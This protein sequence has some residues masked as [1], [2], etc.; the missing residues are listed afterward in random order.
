MRIGATMVVD[1]YPEYGL[2]TQY[3]HTTWG[4]ETKEEALNRIKNQEH[5][6]A[7]RDISIIPDFNPNSPIPQ[8]G[9]YI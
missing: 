8:V 5:G 4:K 2:P 7:I 6:Y 1:F 9:S 3:Y